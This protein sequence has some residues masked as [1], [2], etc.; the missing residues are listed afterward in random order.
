VHWQKLGLLYQPQ[1]EHPQLRSHAANP[2]ALPLAGDNYRVYYSGRDANNRSS[3]SYI[4]MDLRRREVTYVHPQP[5]FTYGPAG[6]FYADGVSIGNC[7]RADDKL[8]MLFM[9]WQNPPDRH[10]HGEIGRLI[11]A[12]DGGL[13]LDKE[14]SLLG[15]DATDPVSLS[16]PWVTGDADI[17][18]HMWY[19]STVSWDAGNGEML[20][21][22]KSARSDDGHHWR[23]G[24][25]AIPYELGVAQAFSRPTVIGNQDQGFHMWYSY[26]PGDGT[27]YRIAYASSADGVHWQRQL[28]TA[29]LPVSASGWDAEMTAYPFVF[30]HHG[31]YYMLYN[32]NG[33]GRSG[34]GLAILEN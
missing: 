34:F 29:N 19:G 6:S 1:C 23:R 3:V 13:H 26:R 10:W 32:G 9:G 8:Y 7:Y 24:S 25:C 27:A 11:V 31:H 28:T 20:H 22:I 33:Y 21:I 14:Q 12:H 15:L 4:E 5:V 17:G 18:Y 2:L 30:Q 16:Y